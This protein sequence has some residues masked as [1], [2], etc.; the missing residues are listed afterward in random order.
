MDRPSNRLIWLLCGA[1]TIA[2]GVTLVYREQLNSDAHWI[3]EILCDDA[4]VFTGGYKRCL[5]H[6]APAGANDPS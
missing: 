4:P 5:E 3:T 2:G 1:V 6:Y